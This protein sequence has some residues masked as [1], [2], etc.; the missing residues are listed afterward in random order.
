M[1]YNK[2][3]VTNKFSDKYM[4]GASWYNIMAVDLTQG[5]VMEN[6][7]KYIW[8]QQKLDIG[9]Y[10]DGELKPVRE[11]YTRHNIDTAVIEMAH[12]PHNTNIKQLAI[13]GRRFGDVNI[14]LDTNQKVPFSISRGDVLLL[15]KEYLRHWELPAFAFLYNF[16]TQTK[17]AIFP[18]SKHD[19]GDCDKVVVMGID[20]LDP[21]VDTSKHLLVF[22][23]K[24]GYISCMTY[25]D[26]PEFAA[27]V[28]D[29]LL[30]EKYHDRNLGRLNYKILTNK[31]IDKMRTDLLTKTR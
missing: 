20:S 12:N 3:I 29:E 21:R 16:S 22:S 31:N 2:W 7:S 17:S 18:K 1:L 4:P 19:F 5:D 14:L 8:S 11:F 30:I 13:F 26:S 28:G 9:T 27:R 25:F 23:E 24:F 15:R 10:T 6:V